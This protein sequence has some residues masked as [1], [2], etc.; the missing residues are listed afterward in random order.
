VAVLRYVVLTAPLAWLGMHLAGA[1]REAPLYGLLVGTLAAAA[2]AS[3]VFH[4]WM[5]AALR[6]LE[7]ARGGDRREAV[8]A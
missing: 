8:R 1:M 5:A 3:V 2:V 4:A 7:P 6:E